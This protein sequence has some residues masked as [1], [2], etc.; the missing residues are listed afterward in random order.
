ML[1]VDWCDDLGSPLL[2]LI[3]FDGWPADK[4]KDLLDWIAVNG[5]TYSSDLLFVPDQLTKTAF[6]L[7]W[8]C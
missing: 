7:R 2:G 3:R 4:R 5:C 8:S 6:L 1:K